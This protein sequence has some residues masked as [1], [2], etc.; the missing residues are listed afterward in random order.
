[1]ATDLEGEIV[2]EVYADL[3]EYLKDLS[4][5][6]RTETYEPRPNVATVTAVTTHVEK[7]AILPVEVDLEVDMNQTVRT[8]LILISNT[9]LL[10]APKLGTFTV[11][12]GNEEWEPL[13]V[14]RW[15]V[16]PRGEAWEIMVEGSVCP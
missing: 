5:L 16:S 13:S 3:V 15:A 10:W 12:N 7:T 9:P 11:T 1:M 4:Y 6:V 8:R 2:Q 14:T